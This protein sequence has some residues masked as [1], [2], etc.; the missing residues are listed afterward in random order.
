MWRGIHFDA[1]WLFFSNDV[2]QPNPYLIH[3]LCMIVCDQDILSLKLVSYRVNTFMKGLGLTYQNRKIFLLFSP[4]LKSFT[5]FWRPL[6][7]SK[8]VVRNNFPPKTN[9]Y[10]KYCFFAHL[11]SLGPGTSAP[12]PPCY[13][14]ASNGAIIS[15]KIVRIY[16][17]CNP[18]IR[19]GWYIFLSFL[20]F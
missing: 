3:H 8:S 2:S 13:T 10:W 9:F 5:W 12:V 11:Y 4:C 6:P 1:N 15:Y 16:D 17:Y 7:T 19:N 14:T 18:I 20:N